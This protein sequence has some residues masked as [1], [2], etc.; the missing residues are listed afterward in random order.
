MKG[1]LLS[2]YEIGNFIGY[3]GCVAYIL[4]MTIACIYVMKK[5]LKED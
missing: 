1:T 3:W 5:Y 4:I 2:I